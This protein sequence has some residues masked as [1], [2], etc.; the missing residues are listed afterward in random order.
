MI[1]AIRFY[2]DSIPVIDKLT[3]DQIGKLI[4][5]IF[6]FGENRVGIL[7]ADNKLLNDLIKKL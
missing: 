6:E 5:K 3:D 4:R 1:D 7:E 2:E